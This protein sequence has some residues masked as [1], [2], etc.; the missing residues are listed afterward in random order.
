ML[1]TTVDYDDLVRPDAIHG[2]LYWDPQVFDD[3]LHNIWYRQWVYIGHDSEVAAA[4]TYV[5]KQLGT[6]PVILTRDANGEVHVLF[7]RCAHLGNLVC[8]EQ[9]GTANSIRCPFHGW[10]Y[11]LDG[12]NIGVPYVQGYGPDFDK[13]SVGMARPPRVESH[14]GF[15]FASMNPDVAPLIDFLGPAAGALDDLCDLS[16]EGEIE[17]TAGW[18]RHR[19]NANWK[20]GYEAA[21][22]GYHPRFVHRGLISLT[23]QTNFEMATDK[24]PARVRS[25]GNGHGDV[26]WPLYYRDKGREFIWNNSSREKMP[27]YVDALE[28][29]YGK[30]RAHQILVD[31][32]P[33]IMICPNLFVAEL[34]IMVL[35]PVSPTCHN[36][37]DTP[38]Q[39]K[40]A[41]ELN[42][43]NLRQT[44]AS[45]GPA[46]M[47]LA[48]DA[49][50]AERVQRGLAAGQPEW[51]L[52]T[53]GGHRVERGEDGIIAGRLT[54]DAG[55]LGFWEHYKKAMRAS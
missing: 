47:V 31:G 3:E 40:G 9:R 27:R 21:L 10:T 8:H 2:S 16:P 53:R 1:T 24:C 26:Y 25:L 22:D 41:F 29:R 33:H 30:E 13:S 28:A 14:R 52:R 4:G 38:I 32:P 44:T 39:W 49:A 19:T 5:R 45:I 46:G 37:I 48:D 18:V 54:D 7:N 23:S 17:L 55:I 35:E 11:R 6:Q 12:S 51:L 50:M 20:L 42:E 43:R 34:F 36:Q 15:V